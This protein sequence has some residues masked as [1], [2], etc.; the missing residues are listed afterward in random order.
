MLIKMISD[1]II[2]MV[3]LPVRIPFEKSEEIDRGSGFG[4]AFDDYW[5]NW[6]RTPAQVTADDGIIIDCEYVINPDDNGKRK[7]VAIVCHGQTVT[8]AGAIKYAKIFYDRGYNLVLF[9]HRY[10][11]KSGGDYCTLGW[12]ESE[13]IKKI[14]ALAKEKFGEDCFIGIHGES[15]GAGSSLRLLDTET[16]AY[17]IADCP[18]AD[19]GLLLDDLAK[20]KALFLAKAGEEN[21]R[22][23]GLE[24]CGYD[25]RA[26]RPIDSV[27]KSPVPICFMHGKNDRLINVKHSRMMFEKSKNPLSEIHVFDKT[28]HAQSIYNYKDEYERI[29]NEFIDK[30]EKEQLLGGENELQH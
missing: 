6:Q 26:V 14:I 23:R 4:A 7:K 8:R 29:V 9:D 20:K 24:M 16:P 18:F 3:M 10:F 17:V 25:F 30:I 22:K 19:T 2:N 15:M 12:K 28:D 13:D 27:E 11:G 21:A 5:N 1:L